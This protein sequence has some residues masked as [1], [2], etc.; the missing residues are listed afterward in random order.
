MQLS[1]A[2]DGVSAD[3]SV[4]PW[5]D[6]ILQL[7]YQGIEEG[8]KTLQGLRSSDSRT[9]DL[10]LALSGVQQELAIQPDIDFRVSVTG[11]Q[12]PLPPSIRHEIYR[13]GKEALVNAFCH[14]RAKCVEFELEYADS[15]LR[16]RI[17]DNGCGIDPEVLDAGRRE[18]HWGLTGMRERATRIGGLLKISSSATAGTEVQLSIP[19]SIAFEVS[20]VD[21][22]FES[23]T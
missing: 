3:S 12:Q 17:R 10:V 18:G 4:K 20:P 9:L 5:L 23:S 16:M 19:S 6:R 11:R 22:A 14:S 21:R 8:R 13:I 7:M 2:L 1:A 15:G